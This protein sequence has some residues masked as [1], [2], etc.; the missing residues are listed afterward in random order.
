[1][2]VTR[3][4]LAGELAPNYFLTPTISVGMYYLYSHGLDQGTTRNTHF[5]TVNSNFSSIRLSNQL[6]LR[7]SLQVYYLK[8]D[9]QDGFYVT[10]TVTLAKRNFPLSLSAIVNKVIQTTISGSDDFVWNA[11]VMYA[12]TKNYVRM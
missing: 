10:S 12:F 7:V 8:L 1:M 5:L 9:N 11:T 2:M 6:F 3:R 4:Y